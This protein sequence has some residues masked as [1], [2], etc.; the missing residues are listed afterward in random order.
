MI[1]ATNIQL[2]TKKFLFSTLLI[3]LIFYFS[4]YT[5]VHAQSSN[6][7]YSFGFDVTGGM[8]DV[9]H[10]SGSEEGKTVN[11]K[12]GIMAGG[13]VFLENM[14]TSHFGIHSGL[15]YAF[16]ECDLEFGDTPDAQLTSRNHSIIIPLYLISSFGKKV[17][18]DILYGLT[19]LHI[20]YNTMSNDNDSTNGIRFI[21]YNQFG[22]GLQLR[23]AF[24]L[25]RFTYFYAGPHGQFYFSNVIES[26]TWRDYMYNIQLEIGMLFKTF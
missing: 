16:H 12:P 20:I 21:N 6:G 14:F 9:L 4:L 26:T 1:L 15:S 17:R 19:Y 8:N 18:L 10:R 2:Y 3:L 23:F 25:N 11:W 5:S 7:N 22:C 13:G 24:A